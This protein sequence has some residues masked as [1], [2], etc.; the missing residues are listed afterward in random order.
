MHSLISEG[1]SFE[2]DLGFYLCNAFHVRFIYLQVIMLVPPFFLFFYLLR[3]KFQSFFLAE[4]KQ[5]DNNTK[6]EFLLRRL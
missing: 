3:K 1:S 5:F 2:K 6:E 4:P